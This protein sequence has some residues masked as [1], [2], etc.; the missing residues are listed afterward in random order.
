MKVNGVVKFCTKSLKPT[1]IEGMVS[2]DKSSIGGKSFKSFKP[3]G[4]LK[5]GTQISINS[6]KKI[7]NSATKKDNVE[8]LPETSF[9][10]YE[11][12]TFYLNHTDKKGAAVDDW[13]KKIDWNGWTFWHLQYIKIKGEC[14]KVHMT[15][16]LMNG[17]LSRSMWKQWD[18]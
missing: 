5:S 15:K 16:N 7:T 18:V 14:E 2:E 8:L 11:F 13:Y 17:F 3:L 6:S 12:K 10:L 9:D 1:C 4:S